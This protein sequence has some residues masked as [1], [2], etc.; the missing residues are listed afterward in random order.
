MAT[1][2]E[3]NEKLQENEELKD[4]DLKSNFETM[5]EKLEALGYDILFNNK[6]AS[7]FIPYDRFKSVISQR[8]NYKSQLED[9]NSNLEK[10]KG[11]DAKGNEELQKMI[12]NNNLL[13]AELEE[14]KFN[15][16]LFKVAKDA[17]NPSDLIP[18]INKDKI[19][20]DK[21]TNQLVGL[22]EEIE[23]LRSTK[24]YLFR[25]SPDSSVGADTTEST[26]VSSNMNDYIRRMAGIK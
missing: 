3:V 11:E 21:K 12:D 23:N 15:L 13:I 19:K 4:F 16:E 9:L 2:D 26:K 20:F 6:E 5:K 1:F 7:E 22:E 10:L 14:S 8:D 18:F 17:N 24:P 25:H